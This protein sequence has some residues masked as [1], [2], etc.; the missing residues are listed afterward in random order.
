MMAALLSAV[1]VVGMVQSAAPMTALAQESVR[2]LNVKT[3]AKEMGRFVCNL[4]LNRSE[5]S[6][7]SVTVRDKEGVVVQCTDMGEDVYEVSLPIETEYFVY[8]NGVATG[9]SFQINKF[10]GSYQM[11]VYFYN[12]SFKDD[13]GTDLGIPVQYVAYLHSPKQPP[14]PVSKEDGVVFDKWLTAMGK[15]LILLLILKMR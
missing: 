11:E 12:V 14:E 8:V 3:A 6:G 9:K 15:N 1:L 13:D 7:Q 10:V 2:E 5:W 4:Y